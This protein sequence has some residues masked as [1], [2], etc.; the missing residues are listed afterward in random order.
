MGHEPE[1]NIGT[2]RLVAGDLLC[3]RPVGGLHGEV[4]GANDLPLPGDKSLSH[5]AALLAAMAVGESRIENFLVSGVTH[6]MLDSLSRLGIAWRLEERTLIVRGAGLGIPEKGEY[7][8]RSGATLN[9]GNSATTLRLLAGALA[10]WGV[11]ATLD[12]SPGL[13]RR[14]MRRIIEPLEQ[15]GVVVESDQG[16]APIRIHARR[17]PLQAVNLALPVASAQVKSCILIAGLS[18]DGAVFVKEPGPSRDHTERMLRSLGVA[19]DQPAAGVVRIDGLHGR[20]L[21]QLETRL[22]GDISS[23]AF[24]ITAALI[25]EESKVTLR[26]V[27]L[28]PTRTGL[29]D[30]YSEMGAGIQVQNEAQVSGE[31]VGDLVVQSSRLTAA[32]VDGDRVVRMIDEF[33]AFS[34]AAAYAQGTTRVQ[35]ALELRHKE[36]DRIGAL[37]QELGKLGVDFCETPD[38]FIVNGSRAVTGGDVE[39]HGD[40]RLAMSLAV[41][42]LA[43]QTEVRVH[44][45]GILTESFPEFVD[46]LR[47]LG[48][49]LTMV[50]E[51]E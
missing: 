10:A 37:G 29:L 32:A 12:G 31:P 45:A 36:S 1:P 13:R 34:I 43:A 24:L 4:G 20:E 21:P 17:T 6:A 28:N 2:D 33:P 18:A 5:R 35:D 40:H 14:P 39:A 44:G 46:V 49:A 25:T 16:C 42:G 41:A 47:G 19:V 27:G 3:V 48:A 11:E 8:V 7:A 23:A 50:G 38:G 51:D 30:T 15:M 9:C 22:P 26:G